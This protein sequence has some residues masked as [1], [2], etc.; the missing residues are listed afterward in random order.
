MRPA[1]PAITTL[2]VALLLAVP[3]AAAPSAPN[4]RV[5]YGK[6]TVS[7]TI[8]PGSTADTIQFVRSLPAEP[9]AFWRNADEQSPLRPRQMSWTAG[10]G[11]AP[12]AWYVHV[13]AVSPGPPDAD[14][15]IEWSPV[16]RF[17]VPPTPG[18]VPGKGVDYA[19][20][21]MR[22]GDVRAA[23]GPPPSLDGTRAAP[24]YEYFGGALRVLFGGGR[25]TRLEVLS[26]RYKVEGTSI[27]VGSKEAA[28]RA[29]VKRVRCLTWRTPSP[30]AYKRTPHRYCY[31]GS[32]AKGAVMTYFAIESGRISN[33]KLGRVVFA[34][35][36]PFFGR[37]L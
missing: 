10:D 5:T 20:L 13:S 23:L 29:A 9:N 7:W 25:V 14:D 27:R 37:L 30:Y 26:G 31:L 12:G 17:T 15:V 3:A 22:A 1:T 16:T 34:K 18:I 6:P 35:Y 2:A 4:A 24:V 21:G 32:R 33:V 19:T 8:P 36:D 11:F 28:L